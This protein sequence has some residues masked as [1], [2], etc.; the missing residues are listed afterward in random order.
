[1]NVKKKQKMTLVLRLYPEDALR[2]LSD[3]YKQNRL[4]SRQYVSKSDKAVA[5][6]NQ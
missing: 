3:L 5:L 4:T 2:V 6:L 1:M